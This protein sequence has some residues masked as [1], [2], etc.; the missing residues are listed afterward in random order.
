MA[1][2]DWDW[3]IIG[4]GV[5]ALTDGVS[6]QGVKATSGAAGQ[7]GISWKKKTNLFD[8]ETIF[9]WRND[10]GVGCENLVAFRSQNYTDFNDC[11]AIGYLGGGISPGA[12]KL[13]KVV[14]GVWAPVDTFLEAFNELI[15]S[16]YKHRLRCYES[17]G[18]FVVVIER[19]EGGDWVTICTLSDVGVE[20]VSGRIMFGS[21]P[22]TGS[23]AV[24][25]DEL[26]IRDYVPLDT[27]YFFEEFAYDEL[28]LVGL[29]QQVEVIIRPDRKRLQI[30]RQPKRPEISK[31]EKRI[32]IP[33]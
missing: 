31:P 25:F 28:A 12:W 18:N 21:R 8:Y 27:Y 15:A 13:Y 14:G 17:G 2:T 32:D 10:S 33:L 22:G 23:G 6:G 26:E 1:I 3:F 9:Y 20:Y 30:P 29:P 16:W 19:F 5:L 7:A 24:S 4:D 11:Y